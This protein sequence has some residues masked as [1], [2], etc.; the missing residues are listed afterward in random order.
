MFERLSDRL[1]SVIKKVTGRGRI[2]EADI[3]LAMREVRVAL[4]EADVQLGVARDFVRAVGARAVGREVL[5]SVSPRQQIV[6]IV[7]DE[8][9]TL[10]GSTSTEL[11]PARAGRRR[12]LMVGLQGSGKTTSAAKL[13]LAVR[14]SGRQPLL[15]AGDLKRPAAIEQL[16][17]LATQIDVPIHAESVASRPEHVARNGVQKAIA[18]S[19]TDV[20]VD[21]AGRIQIDADLMDEVAR[22][23]EH[24]DPTDV[25]LV[26]D[27]M[28]GQEAVNVASEFNSRLSLTG[29]VLTKLDGDA[30]GGALLSIRAATGVPVKYI[31]AGEKIEQLE[32]FHPDRLASRILGMGDVVSLVEKAQATVDEEAAV[33]LE[34]KLRS[35][36]FDL[37]DFLEQIEQI[38][39]MGSLSQIMGMIPGFGKIANRADVQEALTGRRVDRLKAIILSMTPAERAN[40]G[41]IDG[42]RRRRIAAGSGT[43]PRDVNQLLNQYF[44]MRKMMRQMASGRMP[45]IPGLGGLG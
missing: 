18:N 4:L 10:L 17:T 16:A 7:H 21:T 30:R 23:A 28:T 27:A 3:K 40:P 13:A 5:D 39:N 6:K 44:A 35:A 19:Y 32:R 36:T 41:I 43:A 15:V 1:D 26:V 34:K 38:E 24:V 9:T 31:G 45:A 22:V 8:L 42:S 33:R 11:S 25:L 2:R 14:E 12:I 37:S 29:L 20:I